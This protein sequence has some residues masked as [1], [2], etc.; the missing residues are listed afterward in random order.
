MTLNDLD[1][2]LFVDVPQA[3]V[4]LGLDER[5]VRRA[6]AAGEIRA[7]KVGAKW[8]ISVEWLREQAGQPSVP[9]AL[10][11][12]LDALTDRLA[13]RF[14]ARFASLF[15]GRADGDTGEA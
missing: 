13:D 10:M 15:A 6:A 11:P 3:A 8:M 2:C 9:P 5:T 4:L 1:G 12:D 7:S 14:F